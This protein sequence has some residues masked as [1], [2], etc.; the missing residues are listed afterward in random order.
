MTNKTQENKRIAKNTI[1]LYIRMVFI[2]LVSLYTSRVILQVLGV[3]DF[4]IYNL[5]GGIVVM[6]AFLSNALNASCSRFLSI[7]VGSNDLKE[8]QRY[9]SA[10]LLI[11]TA[12]C[13]ILFLFLEFVGIWFIKYIINIPAGRES[14][15]LWVYQFAI[16]STISTVIRTPFNASVIAHERMGFFA[17]SSIAEGL[18]KLAVVFCVPIVPF[19]KLTSFAFLSAFVSVLITLLY[20]LYTRINFEG[21]RLLLRSDTNSIKS[22][23]SFGF[24]NVFIGAA[25]VGWQQGTNILLNIF[26]GVS[27]NATMGITNQ[28]RTAM[29]SLVSNLQTAANPQIIKSYSLNDKDR[30]SSLFFA[31]SKYSF[32]LIYFFAIPLILNINYILELWLG[33]DNIPLYTPEFVL[34][35]IIFSL[36]DNLI[37]PLWTINQAQGDIKVYSIIVS[38]ILLLN[39]PVTYSLF[40]VSMPPISMLI[41]RIIIL[42]LSLSFQLYYTQLKIGISIKTYISEV[43]K[44]ILC[45]SVFTAIPTFL[46]CSN[47]GGGKQLLWS[48]SIFIPLYIAS[49][50]LFGMKKVER[51]FLINYV[52]RIAKDEISYQHH[53]Q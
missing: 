30:Y 33:S 3:R 49:V 2:M 20:L 11:H 16:L 47:I 22:M 6:I 24:W 4:G 37:G 53:N 17:W 46:I 50:L 7:A 43:V 19:D 29:Y 42:L 1:F 39:L 32:L 9:F 28:V 25:D 48:L 23:L 40:Y 27:L 10:S 12:F 34:L 5:V 36:I 21:H 26:H 44:P 38:T 8:I 45:V 51:N 15:T 52:K 35:I 41:A 18:L 31:I 13:I 14:A